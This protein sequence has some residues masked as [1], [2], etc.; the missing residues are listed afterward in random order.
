MAGQKKTGECGTDD[1]L[2]NA[3]NRSVIEVRENV[4]WR[5]EYMKFELML[6]DAEEKGRAE[7][8]AKGEAKLA[9]AIAESEAKLAE[10]KAESEAK[11]AEIFASLVKSGKLTLSEAVE[12]S[13]LTEEKIRKHLEP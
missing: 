6:M 13:G 1:S 12:R 11:L 4:K 7:E 8:R 5:S 2:V 10:V 3:I 9:E